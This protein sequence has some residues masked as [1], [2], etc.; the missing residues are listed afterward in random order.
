MLPVFMRN[1]VGPLIFIIFLGSSLTAL[2]GKPVS[3]RPVLFD[4]PFDQYGAISW[5]A[6]KARL[7]NFAIQ[8]QKDENLVG[9][10]VVFDA[11]G[12]CPGEAQA[13][14]IRAKRYLVEYRGVAWNRVIWRR[15]GYLDGI[16]TVLQPVPSAV[17]LPRPFLSTIAGKDGAS[18]KRCK[19]KLRQIRNS[20]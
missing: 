5:E 8:L 20:R 14:A 17:T 19:T 9:Y 7:D 10:I 18:T 11:V 6:E 13:R 2:T 12:G 15:D 16:S 1:F 3:A 4:Q